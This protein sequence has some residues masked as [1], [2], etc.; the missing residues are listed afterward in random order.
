MIKTSMPATASS[1]SDRREASIHGS[2]QYEGMTTLN[3]G[4]ELAGLGDCGAPCI[5]MVIHSH[6]PI[7][8]GA[9]HLRNAGKC[10][11]PHDFDKNDGGAR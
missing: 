4:A 11:R 6:I 2:P 5:S 1:A 9:S 3:Q 10:D 8:N 7:A